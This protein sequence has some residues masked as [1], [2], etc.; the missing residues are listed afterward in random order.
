M[1]V[2]SDTS[3]LRELSGIGQ[4]ELIPALYGTVLVP[5][6]VVAELSVPVAGFPLLSPANCP[7]LRPQAPTDVLR[8]ASLRV[9]L[10]AGEAEAIALAIETR[11]E[12]LLMDERK[13]RRVAAELGIRRI[14]ILG[15]LSAAKSRG[16]VPE[17]RPLV[18]R[19]VGPVGFRV[20]PVLVARFLQDEGE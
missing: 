13:G 18:E 19:L 3:P 5:P 4:L 2:V 9:G 1:L 14:G 7:F 6:A 11:A 17:L 20:S 10:D 8:V 15:I 16:L 12:A